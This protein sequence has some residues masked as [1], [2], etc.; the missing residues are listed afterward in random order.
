MIFFT[1]FTHQLSAG[2]DVSVYQQGAAASVVTQQ[3]PEG[4]AEEAVSYQGA[5]IIIGTGPLTNSA[6][7]LI[8]A[9]EGGNVTTGEIQ[10]GTLCTLKRTA[11]NG[12]INVCMLL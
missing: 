9:Y 4:V 8:G 3:R 10:K 5:G 2:G 7:G 12:F 6:P 11:L 1:C